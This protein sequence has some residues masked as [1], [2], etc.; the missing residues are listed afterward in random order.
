LNESQVE[1]HGAYADGGAESV[2][3]SQRSE[4]E[5]TETS[6]QR[7]TRRRYKRRKDRFGHKES[8]TGGPGI[9]SARKMYYTSGA[10]SSGEEKGELN[11]GPGASASVMSI[12]TSQSASY[13]GAGQNS[14]I[15]S[16]TSQFPTWH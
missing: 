9:S 2:R 16:K 12:S 4:D 10:A 11:F 3:P 5:N 1:N 14:S 15:I 8:D 13:L 6:E 7:D